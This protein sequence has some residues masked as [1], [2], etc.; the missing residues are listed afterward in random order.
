M[1]EL[2]NAVAKF[3]S[4]RDGLGRVA[5][6]PATG[7]TYSAKI[8]KPE[9]ISEQ[10]QL[11]LA[12]DEG[13]VLSSYDD[14]DGEL[15]AL[16]VGVRCSKARQ[17]IV[18]SVLRDRLLDAAA[19]EVPAGGVAVAYLAPKDESLSRAQGVARVT[20]FDEALEPIAERL[21]FRNRRARL[22]VSVVPE[23][24]SYGPRD[25]VTLQ[26]TTTDPTGE[27]V[28]ASLALSVV[29]D[30]VLS[31]ADDK[32]GHLLS[33]LLLEP[34]LPGKVEEPNFYLDLTEAKSAAALDMLLGTSG[35]RRFE[36]RRLLSP[37]PPVSTMATGMAAPIGLGAMALEEGEVDRKGGRPERPG[38]MPPA[39]RLARAKP[40]PMP[41]PKRQPAPAS[42]PAV[43]PVQAPAMAAAAPPPPAAEP[44][45]MEAGQKDRGPMGGARARREILADDLL[46]GD[47]DL[48]GEGLLGA[49]GGRG[50][51]IGGLGGD[52]E[53]AGALAAEK[54]K[55]NAPAFA[56][57]RVF[58][59]PAYTGPFSG[60]RTDFRE[61]IH[62][63][64]DVRTGKDGKATVAFYLSDAVTSFRVV[65]EG[66]AAGA[67][68]Y[69]AG[70]AGRDE[71]TVRSSLPFSM[72]VKLPQ[73][74]S[75]GDRLLLPLT[76]ASERSDELPVVIHADFGPLLGS[77]DGADRTERLGPGGRKSLMYALDVTGKSG[78][79][80]VAFAA[81]AGGLSDEFSR[82]LTVVPAGFP[83]QLSRS[84]TAQG[85]VVEELTLP[86][87]EAGTIEASVRFYPSPLATLTAGLEGML[88]E[89]SGCFEQASSSN[90][91]NVMVMQY[92][93]SSGQVNPAL[94]EKSQR[95]LD[96]GYRKLTGYEAKDKG[97][98]WFGGSPGHE[99]LTAYGLLEFTDMRGVFAVDNA[100]IVRT[101]SWLR[102][103][104]DGKGGYQRNARA[105]DSFGAASPEV[106]DAY[107]TYSLIEAGQKELGA[108]LD[109]QARLAASTGDAYLLALA[110]N[111]LLA[112][113][114]PEGKR[115]WPGW[116]AAGGGRRL[117]QREPQHH[118]LRRREP[119]HR[120][121]LPGGPGSDSRRRH[122]AEVRKAIEWLQK[123]RGGHGQWGAT[124]ATVLA[125]KAMV[126]YAESTR[127][128]RRAAR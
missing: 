17:V 1:D 30:T 78:T 40:A 110:T 22:G 88:R 102:S 26:V 83:Q 54:K 116:R 111:T 31:F 75:A 56:S 125:L 71:S 67:P 36:W 15:A 2:G 128:R 85:K 107:I 35:Y 6:T 122:D 61:T 65:T 11:P 70:L 74:V 59:A 101:A 76:L 80:K 64:P 115:R 91:P 93:Q 106:T 23:R 109:A 16:R 118:P 82:E 72:T 52:K 12:S 113:K 100:M 105:L 5:F 120:D 60:P 14:L 84:G 32:Q 112:A 81:S 57:V 34:E 51:G 44:M 95:L 62:W 58:P 38:A 127:R 114:R 33:R 29:D 104:R 46:E 89:P 50:A 86:G 63:A 53:F 108:E 97:Y 7:R 24:K 45:P 126:R 68:R 28:P 4:V 19:V 39:D 90:Y 79:S 25:Q 48:A 96:S 124:Q 49:R 121:H 18:A 42:P 119:A 20:L 3:E 103:Q 37:P 43:A 47:L 13:C 87:A 55:Q 27:P 77:K 69:L 41:M 73:E 21:V 123:N 98:E 8:E 99:A 117:Q 9:G 92:M 94:V 10:Y 66:V